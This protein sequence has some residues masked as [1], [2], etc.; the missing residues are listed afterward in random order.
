MTDDDKFKQLFE[1]TLDGFFSAFAAMQLL[2]LSL[3]FLRKICSIKNL[4]DMK[5]ENQSDR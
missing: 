1:E 3:C 4:E 2:S 5:N